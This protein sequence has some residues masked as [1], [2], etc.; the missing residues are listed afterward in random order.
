MLAIDYP[1]DDSIFPPEITAPTFIW[2]DPT[3]AVEWRL[4]ITF[5][6][7]TPSLSVHS[8]GEPMKIG[9]IDPLCLSSTN[10]PPQ[11]TPDQASAH[12]WKPDKQTWDLI[13]SHSTT[14]TAEVAITGL[15]SAGNPISR[16]HVRINTSTDPVGAPIFYRDVPLMPSEG[17]KGIVQPLAP[18][19]LYLINW[20]LR[21]ISRDESRIVMHDQH[22][23][24]NCHSFSAD[25]KTIGIDV[26]GPANDKGLYALVP[27]RKQM[28]IRTEDIVSWNSDLRVGT[29][30]VGFGSQVS[31]DGRY[32][33][34][35]FAGKDQTIPSSYFVENFKDYRFLQVFY[36][37]RGILA[38][39]DRTTKRRQPLP[40]AD[41]PKYVQTGG[42]WSPDGK[43]IVFARA[44]ARDPEPDDHI[45]PTEAN[46]PHELQIR[47]DLYRV[48]FNN[49]RGGKPEPIPGASFNG[50]SNSFPKISPDSRW[51]VFVQAR[52]GQLMRPDSQLYIVP[53]AGG[54]ARRMRCNTSRMNSWHSFSPNGRWIV[55]SSKSR[56]PYTQMFLTHIDENGNDSPPIYVE[57]STAANRAVN[58]PEFV[59]IP[60]DGIDAIATPATDVYRAIDQANDLLAQ[61]DYVAAAQKWRTALA[62]AP[63][64]ARANNGL[65][66]ALGFTGQTAEALLHFRK[67]IQ[68]EPDFFEAHY[69]LAILLSHERRLPEA[70]E[71]W[72]Q[73]LRIRPDFIDGE[74]RLAYDFYLASRWKEAIAEFEEVLREEPDKIF[75]L[76]LAAD[77][78]SASPDPSARNGVEALRLAKHAYELSGGTNP[79]IDDSLAAALA[80]T[81]DFQQAVD[82]EQQ[83]IQAASNQGDPELVSLCTA[84]L[85]RF[86]A[87]QPLRIPRDQMAF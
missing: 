41:D 51:I 58:I 52:N 6:D 2:H 43:W 18:S 60:P 54:Q 1:E 33:L 16:N 7:G 82:D 45:Y 78:L 68:T 39:Y 32:V 72:Q 28:E 81:G 87:K 83:A 85:A 57:N 37:T 46:D 62:I 20:R 4:T 67:A 25:G 36:P 34:S 55:F 44:Q 13:K 70:I 19:N 64:D 59:N 27:I 14:H 21:D 76:N 79:S 15:D 31:P 73:T 53:F 17:K 12:T 49:G 86:Q 69:N 71:A 84:H 40:G 29:E 74:E 48:P 56:S 26:D 42:V 22:T 30:R 5:A 9:E 50:M 10:K 63:E 47:Y 23:C 3:P 75:D 61:R 8:A 24:V 11:L 80:E 38:F 66:I 77:L 65:G 35:T